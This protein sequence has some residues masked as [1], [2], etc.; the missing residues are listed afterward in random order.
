VL[1]VPLGLLNSVVVRWSQRHHSR[2]ESAY[3]LLDEYHSCARVHPVW[4]LLEFA[5]GGSSHKLVSEVLDQTKERDMKELSDLRW[6]PHWVTHLGCVRGCLDYL[7]LEVTDAWIYG[8]TGH[9]F[10]LNIAQDLCSSGPTAWRTEMLFQLGRNLGYSIEGVFGSKH[11]HD[12]EQLQREAWEFVKLSIDQEFPCYGWEL[13]VPEFYVVYGYDDTGYYISG[14]GCDEGRGPKA[15]EELGDTG[16][17]IV[18]VYNLKRSQ[19]AEDA[20]VIKDAL[21]AV[22][23]H[24]SNPSEWIF[25]GYKS[26]LAGFDSWIRDM[27]DGKADRFGLGYNA[28]VWTE[29]RKYAV[30]FLKEARER[31]NGKVKPLFDEAVE[32][33]SE[34]ADNLEKAVKSYPF[35]SE[36]SGSIVVD[37]QSR[38]A[39]KVLRKAR[40]AEAAGLHVLE[41]IVSE[42]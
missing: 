10:I 4:W 26:G 34:V 1:F 28:A 16:I 39:T 30:L 38:E 14:P 2:W 29:C 25:E 7:G 5:W 35:D 27:E 11:D 19:V 9:A 36:A 32:H 12:L 13:G 40:E 20:K 37:D 17:G 33:Y 8:G 23:K 31:V 18:E 3:L 21:R 42:L 41:R 22:L 24:A 6:V 15:W